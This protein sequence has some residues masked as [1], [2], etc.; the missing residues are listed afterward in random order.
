[1][2]KQNIDFF[3]VSFIALAMLGFAEVRS[4]HFQ[5]AL[6][7]IRVGNAIQVERCPISRQVLS[8][9]TSILH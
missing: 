4:W 5:E 8:N 2:F 3:A 9:I 1:M 6:D 7:S